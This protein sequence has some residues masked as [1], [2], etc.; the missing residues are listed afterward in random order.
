MGIFRVIVGRCRA[1]NNHRVSPQIQDS[2]ESER[3]GH[4][5]IKGCTRV[6]GRRW[7]SRRCAT[8]K[9]GVATSAGPLPIGVQLFIRKMCLNYL[10]TA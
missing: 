6:S 2:T 4:A 9:C 10:D 8:E 7:P 5:S 1:G 3:V